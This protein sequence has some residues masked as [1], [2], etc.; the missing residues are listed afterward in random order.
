PT[1]SLPFALRIVSEGPHPRF[2]GLS[3]DERNCRVARRS[4]STERHRASLPTL[5]VPP[6]AIITPALMHALPPPNGTWHLNWARERPPLVW[7]GAHASPKE[8]P[9]PGELPEGVVLDV[10]TTATRRRAAWHLLRASGKPTDG[11]LS[12]NIHRKISRLFSYIFLTVGLSPNTATFLTFAV[13][14]LSA[15]L[16]AQTSRATMI[17]GAALFWFA[18]VADGIDG[19]MARLTH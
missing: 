5:I 12:R 7:K 17:A 14:L 10:S 1:S 8:A 9:V 13:G 6:G 15:W 11:W 16:V 4:G 18:S 2:L 19:E 3:A